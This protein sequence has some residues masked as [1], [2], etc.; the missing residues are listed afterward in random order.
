MEGALLLKEV[1]KALILKYIISG[2]GERN[3]NYFSV[4]GK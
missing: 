2:F 4:L 1:T 3:P